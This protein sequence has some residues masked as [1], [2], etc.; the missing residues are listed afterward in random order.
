MRS[1]Q[2]SNATSEAPMT[3]LFRSNTY[4]ED[5][6]ASKLQMDDFEHEEE[7]E[8]LDVDDSQAPAFRSLEDELAT[9]MDGE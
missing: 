2:A 3:P 4:D 5:A 7:D 6:D 8:D 1:R 9:P